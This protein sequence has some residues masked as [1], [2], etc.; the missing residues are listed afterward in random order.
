[1]PTDQRHT[2]RKLAFVA[3]WWLPSLLIFGAEE[4]F[5]KI[6]KQTLAEVH[7]KEFREGNIEG[8]VSLYAPNAKFFAANKLVAS[9]EK[10][11][12]AFYKRLREVDRIRKIEIDEF[13]DV[14][15]K[16]TLGWV[17]YNYTK[18]YDLKGYDPQFI[19]SHRLEGF[20][21]LNVKQYG[22]A[23]FEKVGDRW[24]IQIMTVIDPKLWEPKNEPKE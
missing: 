23:I 4:N 10:E 19:K 7:A 16:D 1:M 13:V 3:L 2:I 22:T 11:L 24:K 14:G 15:S 17:I 21:T 18:E 5:A 6:A 12:L 9:G 20:S 8:C